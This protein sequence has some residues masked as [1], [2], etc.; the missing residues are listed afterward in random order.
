MWGGMLS[1][2]GI[3]I[4]SRLEALRVLVQSREDNHRKWPAIVSVPCDGPWY[5]ALVIAGGNHV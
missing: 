5:R 4:L 3:P 1:C 2:F